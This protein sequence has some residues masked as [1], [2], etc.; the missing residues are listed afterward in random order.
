MTECVIH[1]K[2]SDKKKDDGMENMMSGMG[3]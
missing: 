3:M 1:E 2:P